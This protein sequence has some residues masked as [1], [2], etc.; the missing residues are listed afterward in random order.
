MVK[1]FSRARTRFQISLGFERYKNTYSTTFVLDFCT[2]A[3]F[4][5]ITNV[6]PFDIQSS[7]PDICIF[8]I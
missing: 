8:P 6:K 5:E 3:D 4:C 7:Q 2:F 1:L